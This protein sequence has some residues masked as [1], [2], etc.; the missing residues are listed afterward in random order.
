M[1]RRRR[2]E[3]NVN[4][5]RQG[6]LGDGVEEEPV[7]DA[8]PGSAS[9]PAADGEEM[10]GSASPAAADGEEMPGSASAAGAGSV[11]QLLAAPGEAA[12]KTGT[13]S[14]P[15]LTRQARQAHRRDRLPGKAGKTGRLCPG[16]ARLFVT[17]VRTDG[18]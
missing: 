1:Q 8:M 17:V 15:L 2:V 14:R 13:P 3:Y 12:G 16:S 4:C 18:I 7:L 11:W 6:R 9:A 5:A 10:P